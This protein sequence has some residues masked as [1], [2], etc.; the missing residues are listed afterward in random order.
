MPEEEKLSEKEL[1]LLL[2]RRNTESRTYTDRVEFHFKF[3]KDFPTLKELQ[4]QVFEKLE[5]KPEFGRLA[6]YV[7]HQFEWQFLDPEF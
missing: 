2:A 3:K 4:E 1:I 5:I 6:L 7:P